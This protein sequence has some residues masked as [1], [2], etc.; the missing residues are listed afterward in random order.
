[1]GKCNGNRITVLLADDT[2][3]IR[4]VVLGFLQWESSIKVVGAAENFSQ[5]IEMATALKPDVVLLDLHMPDH[6][7]FAP[8]LVKSKLL[9]CGSQVLAM[10]ISSS[11]DDK[12]SRALA[13]CFGAIA[14]L[15]KANLYHELIPAIL[16]LNRNDCLVEITSETAMRD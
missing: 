15:D 16:S 8:A 13:E 6:Y 1:M 10:S 3:S 11:E 12:E 9:L 7:A 14:V 2:A 4:K 5:T